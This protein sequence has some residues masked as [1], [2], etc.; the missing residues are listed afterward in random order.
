[1]KPIVATVITVT[2]LVLVAAVL[3]SESFRFRRGGSRAVIC[4]KFLAERNCHRCSDYFYAPTEE[5]ADKKCEDMGYDEAYYFPRVA[6]VFR[7]MVS[8]CDC[9]SDGQ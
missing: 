9:A 4:Q 7:W 8:N 2:A 1:M 6:A 3:D 5:E